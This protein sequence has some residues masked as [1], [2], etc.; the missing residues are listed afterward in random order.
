M[1]WWP[2]GTLC[3]GWVETYIYIIPDSRP[4]SLLSS[5]AVLVFIY[6]TC[7]IG[8]VQMLFKVFENI[9]QSHCWESVLSS[10]VATGDSPARLQSESVESGEEEKF[11]CIALGW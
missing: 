2:P 4:V 3:W 11:S 8:P 10:P 9:L 7:F 5:L 1:C 6:P